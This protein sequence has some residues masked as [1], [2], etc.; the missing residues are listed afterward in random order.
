MALIKSLIMSQAS[1]SVGGVTY[2]RAKGGMY[3]RARSMPVNP[4]T[5]YQ[6]AVRQAQSILSQRWQTTL[7]DVQRSSWDIYA[8][9]VARRNRLGDTIHLSGISMY[10]R[11]NV[12]RI[13]I[14][15][16]ATIEVADLA[17]SDYTLGDPPV[18]LGLVQTAAVEGPPA[19][20]ASIALTVGTIPNDGTHLIVYVSRP[21]SP[22]VRYFNGPYRLN[23]SKAESG[24][25]SPWSSYPMDPATVIMPFEPGVD[26]VVR[27]RLAYPDGRLSDATVLRERITIHYPASG[28]I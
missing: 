1:G 4:S 22:T 18:L 13:Q 17:P 21:I 19:V 3:I 23:G 7:T 8:A 28:E 15:D 25:G 2:S 9:N 12:P 5:P 11:C 24:E 20:P 27:A 10:V 14:A 26:V 6:Q 16:G